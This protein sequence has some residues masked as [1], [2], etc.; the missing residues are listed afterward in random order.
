[1]LYRDYM[2]VG[3][4]ELKARLSHYVSLAGDGETIRVTDRG[5][6]VAILGPLRAEDVI[7]EGIREGWITPGNGKPPPR[8]WRRFPA[9]RSIQELLDEDRGE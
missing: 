1:M 5:R 2:E 4:R 8:T 7:E 3:I 6:L 9:S